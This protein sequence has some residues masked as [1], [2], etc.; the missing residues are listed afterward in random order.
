MVHV[1]KMLD[2]RQTFPCFRPVAEHGLSVVF[3]RVIDQALHARVLQLDRALAA[4]PFAGFI[5]AVPAYASLTIC[6]DPLL[7]DHRLVQQQVEQL[8]LIDTDAAKAGQLREVLVC[9]DSELAPDLAHVA[10]AAGLSEEAVIAAHLS[11]DYHVFMYGFAPG[12]AYLAGVP[13]ALHMPRKSAAV[14]G[15]AAGSVLI[16]GAQCLVSTLTMPTGWWNIG[17][18][19]T[20]ILTG[21][22]QHPFLFDVGDAVRFKRISRSEYEAGLQS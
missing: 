18:S 13:K 5:E 10:E 1:N 4:H 9:Y 14:R 6:F 19:P 11:G 12:Y 15:V 3:G 21:D 2:T 8:L 20:Q 16:A 17:R 22:P 7:T